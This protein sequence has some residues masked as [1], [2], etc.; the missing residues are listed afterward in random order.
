MTILNQYARE[1]LVEQVMSIAR[2]PSQGRTYLR[3]LSIEK[4]RE[5]HTGLMADVVSTFE[6]YKVINAEMI[7]VCATCYPGD[8]IV[9]LFPDLAGVKI[10]HGICPGH[11]RRLLLE[12]DLVNKSREQLVPMKV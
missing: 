6:P 3:S 12:Y 5:V 4:L 11:T 2:L 7:S 1:H 10:S 8:S 9:R